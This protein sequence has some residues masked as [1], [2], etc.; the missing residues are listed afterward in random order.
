RKEFEAD[1]APICRRHVIGV[2]PYFALAS[3]FLTGKYRSE[4]DFGKSVRGEDAQ[5]YLNPR[6]RAV[7]AALD[8]VAARHQVTPAQVALAWLMT[9]STAPIASATSMTQL[10]DI[11]KSA[12]LKL[13][14]D[15]LGTLDKAS[16]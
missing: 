5:Q 9:R 4:K 8:E 11:M 2:I 3:G 6:G 1:L 7:L 15:D 14:D 10:N 13:G 12:T 16:A